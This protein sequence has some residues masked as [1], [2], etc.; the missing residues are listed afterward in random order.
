[1]EGVQRSAM[2][3]S[4]ADSPSFAKV[5]RWFEDKIHMASAE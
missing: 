4:V 3:E 1:M 5:K 2:T